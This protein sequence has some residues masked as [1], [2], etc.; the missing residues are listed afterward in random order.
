MSKGYVYILC[1][2]HSKHVVK[3][4]KASK[5]V[6]RRVRTLQTGNPW[7]REFVTVQSSKWNEIEK[8]VHHV[9]KL[10]AHNKQVGT[11]E[12]FRI[13]PEVAKQILME[14]GAILPKSDFKIVEHKKAISRATIGRAIRA[15][16][17]NKYN[18]QI[19]FSLTRAGANAEGCM[20]QDRT[21]TVLRGSKVAPKIVPSFKVHCKRAYNLYKDLVK[22]HIIVNG[23]FKK[24]YRFSSYS[25]AASVCGLC[26]LNGYTS[27]T[28][29]DRTLRAFI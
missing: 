27:W 9:I 29:G 3:I 17:N 26:S 13:E 4:G 22:T 1:D 18:G 16:E 8:F 24:D 21:F 11:S 6:G 20:E 23:I 12:F 15:A 5:D 2:D 25:L 14:F 10:I 28:D 19:V 7:I